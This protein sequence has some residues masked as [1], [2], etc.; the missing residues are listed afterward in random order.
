MKELLA[1]REQDGLLR[2]L[3][4]Y[5]SVGGVLEFTGKTV[6]NFSSN[7]YLNISSAPSMIEDAV[8]ATKRL[9]CGSGASRLVTGTLELHQ[10]LERDLAQFKESEA[11]LVYSAGYLANLGV[12]TSI[13]NRD[14][15]IFSD[16]LVHASSIDAARLS[17]VRT[18]VRSGRARARCGHSS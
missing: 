6:L 2:T 9:G 16:R 12:I 14:D 1:E 18:T 8:S 15:V 17:G 3:R 11:A 10:Q 5:P 13:M 7:D 4:V